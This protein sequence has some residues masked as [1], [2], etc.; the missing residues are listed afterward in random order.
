MKK[1]LIIID[2]QNDYFKNGKMSLFEPLK[3]LENI[4]ILEKQFKRSSAP[5]IYIQHVN[6][7][8]N[9]PFF[10]KDTV[11]VELHSGLGLNDESMIIVKK[12]PNSFLETDLK[13]TLDELNV[14][15]LI[16][17]G[18]MTHMCV[19]ST[20]RASAELGYK[21]TVISDATATKELIFKEKKVSADDV[22][23][24]F[25]AALEMFGEVKSTSEYLGR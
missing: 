12:Y 15:E 20:A 1:A 18:M 16:I 13:K 7:D 6:Q 9:A 2:V 22:Q 25:L 23:T 11:G 17:T 14:E 19:D 4:N 21:T 5:I 24:S 10:V 8:K 3:A